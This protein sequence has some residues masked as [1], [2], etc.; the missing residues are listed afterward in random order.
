[1]KKAIKLLEKARDLVGGVFTPLTKDTIHLAAAID[2]IESAMNLLQPPRWETPEQYQK[3][4]GKEYPKR[5]PVWVLDEDISDEGDWWW[6]ME[7]YE[8]DHRKASLLAMG[9]PLEKV[10]PMLVVCARNYIGPPPDGWR[11]E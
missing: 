6:L 1:V 5:G 9:V 2:C 4:I 11:P 10:E 3:R 7:Y 8:V